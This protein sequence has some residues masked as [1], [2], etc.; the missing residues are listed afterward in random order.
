[1]EE[2]QSKY[3]DFIGMYSNVFSDEYCDHMISEFE[4][5]HNGGLF[6]DSQSY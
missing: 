6:G 5:F 1:M 2:I 3:T 4:R